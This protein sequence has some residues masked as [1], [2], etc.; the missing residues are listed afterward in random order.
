MREE[1]RSSRFI[2]GN[3]ESSKSSFALSKGEATDTFFVFPLSISNGV[4]Y[5]TTSP[6]DK[7]STL[8]LLSALLPPA[9][10]AKIKSAFPSLSVFTLKE[11]VA[12]AFA[13]TVTVFVSL[14]ESAPV[15]VSETV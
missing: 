4:R 7:I 10:A 1:S 8:V 6:R 13:P 15:D 9:C 3:V 2:A 12:F 5:V 11:I 14:N